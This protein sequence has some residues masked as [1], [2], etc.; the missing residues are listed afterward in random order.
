[1][2]GRVSVKCYW[3]WKAN[4]PGK[5]LGSVG[6]AQGRAGRERWEKE[7]SADTSWDWTERDWGV[8]AIAAAKGLLS[9]CFQVRDTKR[10]IL[11]ARRGN[12][13]EQ[14]QTD[15]RIKRIKVSEENGKGASA[16][17]RC[18]HL[19]ATRASPRKK[20]RIYLVLKEHEKRDHWYGGGGSLGVCE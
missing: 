17:W 13:R 4:E 3:E 10:I 7:V 6:S 5:L 18:A 20:S 19:S 2:L 12:P 16:K 11:N 15:W 9:V 1:M 8:S 14:K